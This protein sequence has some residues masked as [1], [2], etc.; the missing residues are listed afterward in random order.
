V[1]GDVVACRGEGEKSCVGVV[2]GGGGFF[3]IGGKGDSKKKQKNGIF[4]KLSQ[5]VGLGLPDN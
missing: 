5:A 4:Q 1:V 2:C 3:F